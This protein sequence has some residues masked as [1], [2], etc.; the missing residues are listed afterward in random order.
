[1]TRTF[2]EQITAAVE[3]ADL[4]TPTAAKRGR[5]PEWPYVPVIDY[6]ADDRPHGGFTTQIKGK[7]FR[8]RDEAVDYAASHIEAERASLARRLAD[9][10]SRALRE[11]YGLP[12]EVESR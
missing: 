5:N 2:T 9:R 6:R 3:T 8:T 12:R 11:Q 7:A 4:G 1:M 10:G